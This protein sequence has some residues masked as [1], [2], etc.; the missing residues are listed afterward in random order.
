MIKIVALLSAVFLILIGMILLPLPI[1]FGVTLILLGICIAVMVSPF[2]KRSVL[3]FRRSHP[4]IETVIDRVKHYLP[5]V[6]RQPIDES[7]PD[8]DHHS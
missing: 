8:D 1:P 6:L 2:V 4:D 7:D 3:R 5:G